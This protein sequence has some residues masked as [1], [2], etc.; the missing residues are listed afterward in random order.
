M[1]HA[2]LEPVLLKLDNVVWGR[3]WRGG[4]KGSAH[5]ESFPSTVQ[6][7]VEGIRGRGSGS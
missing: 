6:K 1:P 3:G 4:V 5:K 7:K 2:R